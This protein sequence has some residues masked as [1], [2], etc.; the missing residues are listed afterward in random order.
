MGLEPST[1]ERALQ[2]RVRELA[3]SLDAAKARVKAL[4][5]RQSAY[6]KWLGAW[7]LSSGV[8][9]VAVTPKATRELGARRVAVYEVVDRYLAD[10][11]VPVRIE[12]D[13]LARLGKVGDGV[14]DPADRAAMASGDVAHLALDQVARVLDDA[15]TLHVAID[16]ADWHAGQPALVVRPDGLPAD[17]A[18]HVQTPPHPAPHERPVAVG[19]ASSARKA[20]R[21]AQTASP[22]GAP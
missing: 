6:S 2:V 16:T 10:G 9:T 1:T 14:L 4:D 18:P 20:P 5:V 3:F 7:V 15:A 17:A 11:E 22:R 8:R 13:A 21:A 19:R 12:T